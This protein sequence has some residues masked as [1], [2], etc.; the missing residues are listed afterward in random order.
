MSSESTLLHHPASTGEVDLLIEGRK[1]KK[2]KA[3]NGI[4]VKDKLAQD[5]RRRIELLHEQRELSYLY[6]IEIDID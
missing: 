2:A 6:G 3:A 4:R 5:T 1:A